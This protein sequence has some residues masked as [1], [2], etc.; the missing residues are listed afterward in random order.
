RRRSLDGRRPEG[1]TP[2]KPHGDESGF[3]SDAFSARSRALLRPAQPIRT[4]RT[5]NAGDAVERLCAPAP[6]RPAFGRVRG[7][8]AGGD[9]AFL[10]GDG[11]S[12]TGGRPPLVVILGPTASGK[13]EIAHSLALARGGEI[14]SADAFAVYRGFDV[15]TAKPDAR[16]RAEVRYHM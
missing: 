6:H 16:R 15:G 12:V 4:S 5:R 3:R 1:R 2:R 10:E 13:S 7:S 8:R 14:V 11:G 9:A